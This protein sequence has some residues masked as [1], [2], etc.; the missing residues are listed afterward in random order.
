M[1]ANRGRCLFLTNH[2]TDLTGSSIVILEFA[3]EFMSRGIVA[4]IG[5]L[6]LAEPMRGILE[7]KGIKAFVIEQT[8]DPTEYSYI[9]CQHIMFGWI[10]LENFSGKPFPP[11]VIFAHLGPSEFLEL[12]T[13]S[14]QPSIA[15][16]IL[17]NSVETMEAV[18]Q[19]LGRE[20]PYLNFGNAA[21][22]GYF[23]VKKPRSVLRR[24][25]AVSNHRVPEI[26]T[27]LALLRRLGFNV[28]TIG[29]FADNYRQVNEADMAWADVVITIGK[30][31]LYGL[32]AGTPVYIYGPHGGPG[33]LSSANFDEVSSHNFS[34]RPTQERKSGEQISAEIFADHQKALAFQSSIGETYNQSIRLRN[35]VDELFDIS[36]QFSS[37]RAR[38]IS[39]EMISQHMI[40]R[41]ICM[42]WRRSLI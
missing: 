36:S 12:P 40:Y 3:L 22:E 8:I 21:P 31:A 5:C 13:Y 19:F 1:N 16:A 37:A 2:M 34:G 27:G 10:R 9:W 29:V 23:N 38:V 14:L 18:Q 41:N 32:A 33:F 28:E 15:S 30:T 26:D 11:S 24:I 4:D 42:A 7:D 6:K 39:S 17:C 25:L 35:K 20:G